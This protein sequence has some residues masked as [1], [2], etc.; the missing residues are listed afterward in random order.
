MEEK[1]GEMKSELKM[2]LELEL[3]EALRQA[4][5]NHNAEVRSC[6]ELHPV[7]SSDCNILI[8]PLLG[9]LHSK[10]EVFISPP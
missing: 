5:W 1:I 3:K 4:N 6:A 10:N 8:A 7:F 9:N 2:E